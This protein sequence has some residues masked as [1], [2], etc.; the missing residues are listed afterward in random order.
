MQV[1]MCEASIS[2]ERK[3][4]LVDTGSHTLSKKCG[5]SRLPLARR[6][7]NSGWRLRKV[8]TSVVAYCTHLYILFF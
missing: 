6:W 5:Q 7:L 1:A 3:K 2:V 4:P 8:G